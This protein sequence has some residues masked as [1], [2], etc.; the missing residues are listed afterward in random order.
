MTTFKDLNLMLEIQE[1]LEKLG[2]TEPTE[3]QKKAIPLLLASRR[4]NFHGQAQTGTGKTLAFGIPLIERIDRTKNVPQ[5]L[6]VAP[7]RE[8][9]I[10]IYESINGIARGIGI[11]MAVIYG[12]ASMEDQIRMLRQGV[13][14]VVGTPGRLNDHLR[15]KTLSVSNVHTLILDEADIMLDMGF[16]E[17]VDEIMSYI[18]SNGEIWLFSATVKPGINELIKKHMPETV[19]VRVS[20][21]QV[22]A[23]R[24]KQYYCI[25]PFRSR[26]HAVTRFIQASPDF[27][28]FIFCQTKILT[29]EVAEQ[30]IKRGYNVGALHGDMSQ[31]Q[32]NLVIKKFKHKELTI[33]VATD[34]AARGIDIA[35]LTHV[36]NFSI[37]DDPESYIHRIGR[38]GR[39]GKE[40]IAITFISKSEQRTIYQ[41]ERRFGVVIQPMD[42]PSL[43]ELLNAR[44]KE[45][46]D[47]V[48][49][50]AVAPD[51][52]NKALYD[53]V[54]TMSQESLVNVVTHLLYDKFVSNLDLEEVPYTHVERGSENQLQEISISAGSDDG[55]VKEN[56]VQYLT[57][58]GVVTPDQIKSIRILKHRIFVKLASDCTPQLVTALLHKKLDSKKVEVNLTCLV[59]PVPFQERGRQHP[60]GRRRS[61]RYS[62]TRRRRKS[63]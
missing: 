7:T 59:G 4:I 48:V 25:V 35:N 21:Q 32:R 13:H 31:A 30:L 36:I 17:E 1:A 61:D 16:K 57:Q 43:N 18:P 37:P 8:L 6:I 58:T 53:L 39:A 24:T 42:I 41:I 22:G 52:R 34:V 3:I 47:Y 5:G 63:Y 33:L 38:T 12:G 15:R 40:G 62:E 44:I 19:S 50:D 2:F 51:T 11:R 46:S 29:S 10:Q 45:A 55:I 60:Y 20:P 26:L 14:I 9:A 56:V 49:A 27:Y 54:A 28:G 23:P